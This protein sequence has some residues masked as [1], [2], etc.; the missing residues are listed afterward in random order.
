MEEGGECASLAIASFISFCIRNRN[1]NTKERLSNAVFNANIDVYNEYHGN[2]GATLS[3]F[4]ID[5][6]GSFEAINVGDSRIY[7]VIEKK[8]V[9][10]TIDDTITGQ[11]RQEYNHSQLSNNLLQY[12]GMGD[13]IEPHL[14]DIPPRSTISKMILTSDGVHCIDNKTLQ[15]ILMQNVSSTELAKRLI[16]ISKWCGGNDNASLL[17][18]TN[19]DSQLFHTEHINTGV[20]QLWDPFGEVVFVGIETNSTPNET[21]TS[22]YVDKNRNLKSNQSHNSQKLLEKRENEQKKNSSKSKNRRKSKAKKEE[23]PPEK[24]QLRIDFDE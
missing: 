21:E 9:Q 8:L 10:I 14:L 1:L 11:L 6:D 13:G 3:A 18:L 12:I 22:Q 20:V 7:L 2:A 19:L 24:L 15:N 4:V 16:N 17:L 5:S 23:P